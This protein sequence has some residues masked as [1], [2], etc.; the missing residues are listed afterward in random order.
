MCAQSLQESVCDFFGRPA[1]VSCSSFTG[2]YMP[3][4]DDDDIADAVSMVRAHRALGVFVVPRRPSC[5]WYKVL[6]E[7]CLVRF[8]LPAGA[9]SR[10]TLVNVGSGVNATSFVANFG[11]IGRFK[12]KRRPEKVFQ[13][14]VVPMLRNPPFRIGTI[15]RLLTRPSPMAES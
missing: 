2:L 5:E 1:W 11:W 14:Q 4:V 9:L 8:D 12:S 6:T 3:G 7:A 13:L 15:P 10:G